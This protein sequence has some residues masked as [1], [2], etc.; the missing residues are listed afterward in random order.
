MAPYEDDEEEVPDPREYM[1]V[2][3]KSQEVIKR[4]DKCHVIKVN[5]QPTKTVAKGV[6][7]Q[8]NAVPTSARTSHK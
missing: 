4:P 7:T 6:V 5:P 8:L 3:T 2:P 1:I